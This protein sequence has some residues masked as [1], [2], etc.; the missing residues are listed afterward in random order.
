M[1]ILDHVVTDNIKTNT[2]QLN[3]DIYN[4]PTFDTSSFNSSS[5]TRYPL[6][7]VTVTLQVSKKHMATTVAELTYL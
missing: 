2:Y 6:L 5:G 1:N 3:E 4:D 7:V